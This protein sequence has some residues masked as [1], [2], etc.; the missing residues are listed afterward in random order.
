[1]TKIIEIEGMMCAH[2]AGRVEEA[3]KALTGESV[4]VDLANKRAEV[5]GPAEDAA[6]KAAVEKAGYK[7]I[8]IRNV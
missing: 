3:L 7:V 8:S 4:K 2:C 6:L 1:M 5:S